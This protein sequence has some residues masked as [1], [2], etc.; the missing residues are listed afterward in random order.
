[1]QVCLVVA[2]AR[3]LTHMRRT[4][5]ISSSV[6]T[7]TVPNSYSLSSTFSLS[8][9]S[10]SV[11]VL[12]F[13]DY[14]Y[15]HYSLA[16]GGQSTTV[17]VTVTEPVLSWAIS[18]SSLSIDATISTDRRTLVFPLTGSN[19]IIVKIN[20]LRE[21]V[22]LADP[23]DH[24]ADSFGSAA[25]ILDVTD[26]PYSADSTGSALATAAL[27][28]ALD[29]AA[30][31][32]TSNGR[33]GNAVVVVPAGLYTIGA[34]TL[35]HRTTLYVSGGA[36]L[37]AST[38]ISDHRIAFYKEGIPIVEW[39]RT[40][41]YSAEIKIVG[42]GT[43]DG[44][45]SDTLAASAPFKVMILQPIAVTDFTFDGLLLRESGFW[46]MTPTMITNAVISNFKVVNNLTMAEND[47]I[48]IMHSYNV[49]LKHALVVS[50]DDAYSLKTWNRHTDIAK[51]WPTDLFVPNHAIEITDTV[52]WTGCIGWKIGYGTY[53]P[54]FNVQVR[55]STL[56]QGAIA[57]GI[58]SKQSSYDSY[59][60]NITY[61]N[62]VVEQIFIGHDLEYGGW[63]S[64]ITRK[65]TSGVAP[66]SDISV[67]NIDVRDLGG[68]PAYIYGYNET[69]QISAV[70]LDAIK[71]PSSFSWLG[72]LAETLEQLLLK[73][74]FTADI[75]LF[76]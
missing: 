40:E 33:S 18:P 44:R 64:L 20:G 48:D 9:D 45:A 39:I 12:E 5:S 51:S 15:A 50:G 47:G 16:A 65:S 43:L 38:D 66:V 36:Y 19:Y 31:A 41:T 34:I 23:A 24:Y 59:V 10:S 37:R 72:V 68:Y 57:V 8:V 53:L 25:V 69:I 74:Q 30:L 46:A 42:R 60:F 21:L 58:D 22:I 29:D 55:N 3:D 56:Y 26:S 1:M 4:S 11:P 52:A 35:P 71:L 17:A 13:I 49:T 32:A 14:D 70:T 2:H 73:R 7:Y 6:S 27:Q 76:K 54:I 62:I 67:R 28:S 75:T 61:E 63:L